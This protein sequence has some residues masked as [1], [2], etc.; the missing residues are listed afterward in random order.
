MKRTAVNP[1]KWSL[2]YS[3]NQAEVIEGATRHLICSGQTAIDV[4]GEPQHAGD[5]RAQVALSLDNLETVLKAAEM[6]LSNV[7]RL[8]IYTTD[9]DQMVANWDVLT[10]R[11]G[12]AGVKPPLTLVGIARLAF[13][14]LL[15]EIEATAAG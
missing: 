6:T 3:F 11:L 15:V 2:P 8:T 7:V 14:E 9:V 13:P 12:T 1:W 10:E 4:D 5:M